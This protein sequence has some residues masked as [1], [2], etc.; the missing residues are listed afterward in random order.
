MSFS[1]NLR[2]FL[3]LSADWCAYPIQMPCC[4]RRG[5]TAGIAFRSVPSWL[6]LRFW[7]ERFCVFV[8][9]RTMIVPNGTS[10]LAS[11]VSPFHACI[12][13]MRVPGSAMM[14]FCATTVCTA[15]RKNLAGTCCRRAIVAP[16]LSNTSLIACSARLS[17]CSKGGMNR[18]SRP[19]RFAVSIACLFEPH[20]SQQTV[21]L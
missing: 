16:A 4:P 6:M 7:L 13:V 14:L 11:G 5:E 3:E 2:N 1:E 12:G 8:L 17:D 10:S 20:P 19:N 9:R 18:W 15:C 21:H